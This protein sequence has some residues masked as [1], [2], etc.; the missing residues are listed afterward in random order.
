[1][2]PPPGLEPSLAS[3]LQNVAPTGILSSI[4]ATASSALSTAVEMPPSTSTIVAAIATATATAASGSHDDRPAHP[5][6]NGECRLLG[7]FA[8]FVQ[9]AL[10]CLALLALVYKRWRERPQRPMKIWSFDVSKQVVGGVLVH[11]ANLLMS[12]LSSGQFSIKVDPNNARKRSVDENGNYQP[13]PCSFYLLNL[14][15][16]TTIGIPILIFLLRIF[17]ALFAMT[18]FGKPYESIESGN[19]GNPPRAWWWCKQSMIYFLGLMGMKF[20]VLIIFLVLPWI[21]RI[22]DW[23]LRWTE[24]DEAL[25][26]IFVM[27][28][29][30]VI[31]NATQYYI[32]DSFIKGQVLE[33]AHERIP[34][35]DEDSVDGRGTYPYEHP[36][37]SSH[38]MH[39]E[40]EDDPEV[41]AKA[42]LD[43]KISLKNKS[44]TASSGSGRSTGRHERRSSRSLQTG[45][46]YDPIFDGES[47]PTMIGSASTTERQDLVAEAGQRADEDHAKTPVG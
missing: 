29:F 41:L 22:G 40:D 39:S 27:L 18:P 42:D 28:V 13:N 3:L 2:L 14:A 34:D 46:D 11:T 15:I 24:G 45:K 25:Q 5:P 10:G 16:D 37:R 8:I 44:K 38:E 43:S 30:P 12:M 36:A 7:P 4:V 20:C 32:I 31:M 23:A 21:S 1:M 35:E 19:Y 33:H 17:T 26:V 6:P 9:G 47:S